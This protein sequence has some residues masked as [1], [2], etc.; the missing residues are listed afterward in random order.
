M[1]LSSKPLKLST[2]VGY[3]AGNFGYGFVTQMITSYLVFYATA[4]L[5][6]PGSL[7]GLVVSLSIV[8]DAISDPV[9]GYISD[10]TR[11]K[12]GKRHL[13]ILSGT[14]LIA[15]TNIMLW[16]V[17]IDIAMWV[18][19]IWIFLSVFLI[20]TFVTVFVT[21]YAALGAELST[22][23]NERSKI[24]AVKTIF[25]LAALIIVTAVCM[26]VFFKPTAE[27]E[28]GQ[29]NPQAYKNI[30]YTSSLVMLLTGLW[31]Y[32]STKSYKTETVVPREKLVLTEF[33]GQIRYSLRCKDF[34]QIFIGYLFTNLASA[35]IGVVGLHTFT[36]TFYMNNYKISAV[37]GTQFLVCILAQPLWVKIARK[38]DK[39][40]AVKLGL[41]IS[42]FG[43]M[44]LLGL[45]VLRQQV[46]VHYEYL[47]VYAVVI[48]FGTSGLFS[49]PLSMV[50]DTVD[51]QELETSERSEGVY[52]G[53]LNFG[54][55]MSQ[56]IAILI[57][58]FVL[59]MIRFNPNIDIQNDFTSMAL[60]VVLSVGSLFSF[61]LANKAYSSYSLNEE[62]VEAIQRQI[63]L[64]RISK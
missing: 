14:F 3:G 28:L 18:K 51:Q 8:W 63:Q 59:D 55:K 25:F 61:V 57:L 36:Y 34:R 49:L 64:K 48:G 11:S 41:W 4:V 40:A 43:C 39:K 60:G 47:I 29:F 42:I 6:L 33:V 35:F 27:Y 10:N 38:I 54:Y 45:V 21:P 32:F 26:V 52:F 5:L 23:Y 24:Q 12:F 22:D 16:H 7:I 37:L 17:K 20:K 31:T 2:I 46:I 15:L 62:K 44:M 9:M 13:Y 56:S 30:A 1:Q 58:G 50:A 19:F 53:M